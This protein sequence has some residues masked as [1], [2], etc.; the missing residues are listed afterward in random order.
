M[1]STNW[2]KLSVNITFSNVYQLSIL[3]EEMPYIA[4]MV[5]ELYQDV[6]DINN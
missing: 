4:D 2:D 5:F 1:R 6:K 3:V